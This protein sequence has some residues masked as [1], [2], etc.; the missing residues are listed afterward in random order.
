MINVGDVVDKKYRVDGVC[1]DAGG[2]G[3]VLFI[4]SLVQSFPFQLVLK[5]CKNPSEEETLRFRREVRLLAA[6]AG[7][8]KVVNVV[9][10]GLDH[11]PPYFVMQF[12][13]EGDLCRV[14]HL[15]QEDLATQEASF[16]QM[17]DCLQE[18]HAKGMFHRDIKPQNFLINAGYLVIS[19]FGLSTE[20]GSNTAFT[21]SSMHWGT[22]GFIPPEFLN[23]GFKH[24]TAASDIFMLGKTMY[25]LASNRDPMYPVADGISPQIFFIIERCCKIQPER[26]YQSLAELR[27]AIV[28]AFDVLTGRAGGVGKARQLLLQITS[29]LENDGKFN[30]SDVIGFIELFALLNGDD[31]LKL[32]FELPPQLF[33]VLSNTELV[34]HL[35]AFLSAYSHMVDGKDYGWSYAETIASNMKEVFYGADSSITDKCSALDLAIRASIYMNRFAAMDTCIEIITHVSDEALGFAVA[36]VVLSHD[37]HFLRTIE[38]SSCR[39][40]SVANAIRQL[41]EAATQ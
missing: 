19:D 11:D 26:R 37:E 5:Y 4:T 36:G 34:T 10:F 2:M 28:A 21:R 40:D 29:L 16:L 41:R 30:P 14:I 20:I 18:L 1:S 15:I 39:S 6:Y 25:V 7:N 27:Q 13:P 3:R 24:A 23:G 32:S 8:S 9:D 35:S 12:Y 31:K 17:I 22:Q 33:S 38:P